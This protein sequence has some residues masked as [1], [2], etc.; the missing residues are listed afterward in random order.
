MAMPHALLV[1][2]GSAVL[3][4]STRPGRIVAIRCD[5]SAISSPGHQS[6]SIKE[7]ETM[8]LE[9]PLS[10]FASWNK[11]SA[12][13]YYPK[14]N[15]GNNHIHVACEKIDENKNLATIK[16]VSIKVGGQ[17]TNL[18]PMSAVQGFKFDPNAATFPAEPVKADYLSALRNAG[19]VN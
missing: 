7:E 13:Y 1:T 6:S 2:V 18:R 5:W 17:S 10:N 19:L 11:F 9:L 8:P 4:P 12:N 16:S 14:Q 3:F 15:D